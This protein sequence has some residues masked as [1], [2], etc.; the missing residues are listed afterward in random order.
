MKNT[1]LIGIVVG[2]GAAT[3]AGIY[4]YEK[5]A[6]AAPAAPSSSWRALSGTG[7][8]PQ[9]TVIAISVSNPSPEIAAT[10]SGEATAFLAQGQV[11]PVGSPPPADWPSDDPYGTTALRVTGAT[12]TTTPYNTN[13]TPNGKMWVKA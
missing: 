9:G 3:A 13:A 8:L 11:Y 5:K 12:I 4:L 2:V 10:F 6:S 1:S 7:T